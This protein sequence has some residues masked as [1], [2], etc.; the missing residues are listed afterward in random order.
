MMTSRSKLLVG[1]IFAAALS[2]VTP[3]PMNFSPIGAIALFGGAQF[4][5]K[6]SAFLL[7]LSAMLLSDLIVGLHAL[8]PF[9]YGSFALTV[10]LGFWV[11]RRESVVR[12][13]IAS[14][15]SAILF[16]L[17]TNYGVWALLD[18]FPKNTAGL[19]ACYV[20]GLPYFGNTLVSQLFYGGLLF[21]GLALAQRR[22]R[23]A[24]ATA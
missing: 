17:I 5:D 7:P 19:V 14:L 15:L 2:Q 13:A 4:E 1:M 24:R 20:A 6:R 3:H 12:F 10:L 11:R 9:V 22:W 18:T 8:I 16:F 21:G 23:L